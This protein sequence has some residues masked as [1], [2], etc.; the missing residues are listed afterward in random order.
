MTALAALSVAVLPLAACGSGGSDEGT[1]DGSGELTSGPIDIWYSTNEQEIAWGDQVVE[2]WNTDHPDEEVTAQAIPAGSSSE[3]VIAA[4]ITAGN[5]PCL[6]FNTAPSAVPA[7]Q[8]QGG[9]VDL[10]TTFEDG[11]E[12][13]TGRSGDA[14]DGFRSADGDLYQIPWKTNPFMLYYNKDV[15]ENA[16]LDPE[17]PKLETYDDVLAAAKAIKDSGSA[18][19]AIYPPATADYTNVNFDFYPFFLANSDGTQLIE[20]GKSTF[21]SPEGMETLEFWQTLYAEGY[22]SAEAYSGDMWAGP[23]ADGVA[24]MGVAGP[25]GKAQF[26]GKVEFG[27]VPLPT[28]DGKA[29]DATSTFADSKNIGLYTA[30]ENKQTAWD[31]AKFATND[32]NDLALLE[33]TGQ[34][35]TRTDASELAA[36]FLAENPFFEPFAA[37]VPLAVDVPTV[38]GLAEKMQVFR[39][40]WSGTV[41]SGSGDLNSTFDQAA[42]TV[43]GLSG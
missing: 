39:D 10:S 37:A 23:F 22:S 43:D 16:G 35:P 25:W 34:F 8:K 33:G 6:V 41:Q 5:T 36:D 13:V 1:G 19:F 9:L 28:V 38:D 27:V 7:F 2:A 17:S 21:T 42:T 30:C 12:Y 24:A 14:A 29:A 31:F 3:D 4:S 40:A 32:D 15:F 26:D 18:D 11:E 20:D